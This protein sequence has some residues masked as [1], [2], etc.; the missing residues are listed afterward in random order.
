MSRWPANGPCEQMTAM[1]EEEL[2]G[3]IS[4]TGQE[5]ADLVTFAHGAE[6]QEKL[7][8]RQI[9]KQFRDKLAP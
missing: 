5:L 9:P 6:D 3:V 8:Q 1:Q 2:G 4:L 7:T